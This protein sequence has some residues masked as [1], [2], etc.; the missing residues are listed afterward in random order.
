MGSGEREHSTGQAGGIS[1]SMGFFSSGEREAPPGKP[2]ASF[3]SRDFSVAA[4]VRLHRASRW[5]LLIRGF[6]CG[7]YEREHSTGQAGGI[8]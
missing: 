5:H 7:S 8:F 4:N 3:G 6:R 1:W 2:V